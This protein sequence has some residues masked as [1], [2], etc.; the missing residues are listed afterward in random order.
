MTEFAPKTFFNHVK[1]IDLLKKF[2]TSHGAQSFPLISDKSPRRK[3]IELLMDF[4]N[5]IPETKKDIIEKA[6]VTIN[7]LSTQ[8]GIS[9]LNDLIEVHKIALSLENYID[10]GFHDRALYCYTENPQIFKEAMALS[11]F[12]D[13]TGWKRY[14][15]S[16]KN[17]DDIEGKQDELKNAFETIFRKENRGKYCFVDMQSVQD[18]LYTTITF[19]DYP[20]VCSQIKNG[21]VDHLSM[22]RPLNGIYFL[23]LPSEGELHIK[24]KGDWKD[25]D[26]YLKIFLKIVFDE[27]MEEMKQNYNLKLL[28]NKDFELNTDEFSDD[29]ESWLLK[30]LHLRY[31]TTKKRI[32]LSM[33]SR[34]Y[35]DT[36]MDGIWSMIENLGLS[37]QIQRGDILIDK[38]FFSLRFKNIESKRG[39]KSVSFYIDWKDKCNL[40]RIDEFEKKACKI[41]QKSGIDAGF[42]S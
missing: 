26:E 2:F 40:G 5:T 35:I 37:V 39:I 42:T 15:V 24:Y 12:R 9:I 1:R 29:I 32:V 11:E 25:Q 19:E 28:I 33:P 18:T 6:L 31:P 20:Q 4:Y 16:Q 17:F 22:F 41:L 3:V 13:T 30:S 27:E 34:D 36:G 38:A 8:Q 14:P 21:A 10:D 23:Y 7:R